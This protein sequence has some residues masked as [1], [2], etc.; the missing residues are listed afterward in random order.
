M[1]SSLCYGRPLLH[2]WLLPDLNTIHNNCVG[3]NYLYL[4]GYGIGFSS[5]RR[6]FKS[7]PGVIFLPCIYSFVSLLRTLLV[8]LDVM[9]HGGTISPLLPEHGSFSCYKQ[10]INMT[11]FFPEKIEFQIHKFISQINHSSLNNKKRIT[12]I[13]STK[14]KLYILQN[15]TIY[16]PVNLV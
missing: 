5:R 16:I 11:T 12:V 2:A 7:R 14:R 9:V 1:M 3:K 15:Q 13:I 10:P 6:W 8:R 4:N